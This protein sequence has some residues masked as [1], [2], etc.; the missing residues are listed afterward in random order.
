MDVPWSDEPSEVVH[1]T[2]DTFHDFVSGHG[3]VLVMFYAPWCGHCKKA[4]PQF[5]AA[6]AKMKEEGIEGKLAGVDCTQQSGLA[7]KYEVKGYPTIKYFKVMFGRGTGIFIFLN[8]VRL[9]L[10]LSK[11][12][13][14]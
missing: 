14:M 10:S 8:F 12:L 4:K 7:T 5:V 11:H 3:S 9:L 13:Q 2:D 6:A 1:L